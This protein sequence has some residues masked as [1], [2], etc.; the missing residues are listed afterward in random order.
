MRTLLCLT[1]S[2]QS[3]IS[4]MLAPVAAQNAGRFSF[5]TI[6]GGLMR[7]D[8]ETGQI[9]LCNR[10]AGDFVCRS[11]AD[12]RAA[13]DEEITRLKRENAILRGREANAGNSGAQNAQPK[14]TLPSEQEI[15][16]A[17]G[18]FERLMRRMMRVMRDEPTATDRL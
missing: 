15:D 14:L 1:F 8:S 12:D 3:T 11:V 4:M 7:L 5:Q 9:S 10:T 13:L 6:E 2:I 17:M 16:K 18:L